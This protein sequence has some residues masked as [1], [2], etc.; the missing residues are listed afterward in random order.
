MGG[1]SGLDRI[2]LYLEGEIDAEE[3]RAFEAHLESCPGCRA[4]LEGR[5]V[6]LEALSGLPPVEVPAGFA[7]AVMS[8]IPLKPRRRFGW[9]ALGVGTAAL[10]TALLVLYLITGMSAG[11]VLVS[12]GSWVFGS[13]GRTV[14]VFA[15]AV[16]A[17]GV[18]LDLAAA[19]LTGLAKWLTVVAGAISPEAAA[20]IVAAIGI[21]TLAVVF[22][23]KRIFTAGD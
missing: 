13:F 18:F 22:G 12:A 9:A 23:M 11:N 16:T 21:V 6:F 7:Q 5:R 14:P 10:S 3:R 19:A 4:V 8:R 17:L 20:G 15:K 2:D 1:C